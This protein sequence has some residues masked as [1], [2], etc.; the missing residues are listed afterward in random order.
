MA[1]IFRLFFREATDGNRDL[2][3]V[4]AVTELIVRIRADAC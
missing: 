1:P 4:H 2:P 3:N